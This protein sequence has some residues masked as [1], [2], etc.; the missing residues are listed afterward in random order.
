MGLTRLSPFF[1]EKDML[2]LDCD[3]HYHYQMEAIMNKKLQRDIIYFAISCLLILFILI[4][5][6]EGP[7]ERFLW[8]LVYVSGGYSKAKE[9]VQL[10]IENKSLNVEFLMILAAIGAAF[11]NY[12]TE[13]AILILIFSLSGILEEYAINKAQKS[14]TSLLTLTPEKAVLITPNG[15]QVVNAKSLQVNDIIKV[16]VGQLIPADGEIILGNT[17]INQ[18]AITGESNPVYKDLSDHVYAGTL[19]MEGFIQVR[20]TKNPADFLV[21]KMIDFV[22][23]AQR[24]KTHQQTVIERFEA[25]YV[26]IVLALAVLVMIFLS[27][28]RGI[29]LLV[30]ASP[31]ALVASI[32]PV[33]LSAMSWGGKHGILIKGSKVIE[34]I[35]QCDVVVFDKTGTIT[36][37]I[38]VVSNFVISSNIDSSE[39]INLVYA[40]EK[41]SHHPLAKVIVD[42]LEDKKSKDIELSIEE[43]AGHGIVYDNWKIGRFD[44]EQS[45]VD[46]RNNEGFTTVNIIRDNILV[47]YFYL[48]DTIREDVD[49]TIETLNQ[50]GIKTLLLTGDNEMSVKPLLNEISF[51]EVYTNLLPQDKVSVIE[52]LKADG[53]HVM[54]IGDGIND[55]PSLSI[56]DVGVA[57]GQGSDVALETADI[58]FMNNQLSNTLDLLRLA[59]KSRRIVISNIVFSMSVLVLL[60][61]LNLLEN[62]TLPL[63]VFFHEGSTILVILNG[64]RLLWFNSK[65]FA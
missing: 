64:L 36:L 32:S 26:Y 19:N 60:V 6:V 15:D 49:V 56:A 8:I 25:I 3:N 7:L 41:Q 1:I 50:M 33:M 9:G 22:H 24:N 39:V 38:P 54:M 44:Y 43:I 10:T 40:M 37:G 62:I 28:Y 58:V 45:I 12:Y 35:H 16:P 23:E 61:I 20:V 29:V 46:I 18:A 48:R 55:A 30:V 52:R 14:L 65:N 34:Q 59:K 27:V 11:I 42:Y 5:K 47:A 2:Q 63:G 51:N 31:C 57:M 21:T 13:G 53:H 4:T 17:H